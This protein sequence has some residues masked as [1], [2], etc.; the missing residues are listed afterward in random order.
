[1][2]RVLIYQGWMA[3]DRGDFAAARILLDEGLAICREIGDRHGTAWALAR[4]GLV[5]WW[6][7]DLVTAESLLKQGLALCRETHDQLGTAQWTYLLGNVS[8]A[9]GDLDSAEALFEEA[10]PLCRAVGDRR[11]LGFVR[12]DLGSVAYDRGELEKGGAS[13]KEA[14]ALFR[15][16]GDPMGITFSLLVATFGSLAQSQ[17]ARALRLGAATQSQFEAIGMVAPQDF[18]VKFQGAVG[19]ARQMLDAEVADAAWMEGS[20]M[21]LEQ[22]IAEALEV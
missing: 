21:S 11:D 8:Y 19:A 18:V 15:E 2:A 13:L 9:K 5:A 4:L 7:G 20:A 16:L 17:P 22:A 10:A 3:T 14:L 6:A 1:M 12:I